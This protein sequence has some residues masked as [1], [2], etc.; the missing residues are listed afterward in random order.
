MSIFFSILFSLVF[1]ETI[2]IS[3]FL[4]DT[5]SNPVPFSNISC[6]KNGTSSD[7]DGYFTI[8]CDNESIVTISHINYESIFI[9]ADKVKDIVTLKENIII[10]NDIVVK[11]QL[12]NNSSKVFS[13]QILKKTSKNNNFLNDI[14]SRISNINYASGTS[15]PR[16]F[17]IRGLGEL[18]QFSG[19]GA[20]NYYVNLTLDNIDFSG[21]SLPLM[22]Y[23]INQIEVFKGPNSTLFGQNATGGSIHIT[24]KEPKKRK[25]LDGIFSLENFNGSSTHINISNI[26]TK[27]TFYNLSIGKYYSDGWIKNK[28]LLN[29]SHFYRYDTNSINHE[30]LKY[31]L[32]VDK[33]DLIIK[34]TFIY[35]HADN[36]YDI[37]TPD[38]NGFIT[39]TD[40]RG[41]DDQK[42]NAFS[43]Y[44]KKSIK[45]FDVISISSY[46]HNDIIYSYDSDWG[47]NEYWSSEPFNFNNYYYGYYAPYS[48]TDYT[49]RE[50]IN[51]SNELRFIYKKSKQLN[52]TTGI[53]YGNIK[54]HDSRDGWL[55]AG[56]ASNINSL[57]KIKNS[58]VYTEFLFKND[59]RL[60][61]SFGLRTD[62]NKTLN[63]LGYS[64]WYGNSNFLNY[65]IES[66][67]LIAGNLKMEYKLS[68]KVNLISF[69]ST[70]YKPKGINQSP[71]TPE[72]YKIY[73]LETSYNYDIGIQYFTN[74]LKLHVSTFFIFREN[75][76]LRLFY[77]HDIT[78]PN[79]FDYAVFNSKYG[80]NHGLEIDIESYIRNNLF[81]KGSVGLLKTYISDFI[82]NDTNYGDREQAHAPSYTYSLSIDYK[83]FNNIMYNVSFS[84]MDSF[85]FDDQ[86]NHISSKRNLVDMSI[87]YKK[88]L[89][90]F[91]IWSK[92]VNDEKYETRGYTFG[93][94]PP[95]YLPED[96]KAYGA[97]KT[98]GI[99]VGYSI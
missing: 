3:S 17:Q 81:L 7:E 42:T 46:S 26:I 88:S 9:L 15:T 37:W 64:D 52:I 22:L 80:Q 30:S 55:F 16:Y 57:F 66:N 12:N 89:F 44:I 97:P 77:Q 91:K 92:N 82:Y 61:F 18:S 69:F 63:N 40:Y 86:N 11:G 53:V 47:N 35:S 95:N 62:N 33:N 85:Y 27:N 84:G 72:I 74:K 2:E 65:K 36:K 49:D 39:Y 13:T 75:P 60:E 99:T 71:N 51:K 34:T 31:K 5:N 98:F 48:Y 59:E 56:D 78:N 67:N 1:C 23:D 76:Q 14:T 29:G 32:M 41:V 28:Q 79:S 25:S 50:K 73:D 43:I 68:N 45:N 4:K 58:A 70:G 24:S 20:P 8:Y 87:E 38:N 10:L 93:L 96:Y 21:L 54:E 94:E 19:E 6:G 90:T 83:L